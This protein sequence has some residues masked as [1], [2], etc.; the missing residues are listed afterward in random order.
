[1]GYH[2]R[3]DNTL[4]P[5]DAADGLL[6]VEQAQQQ[7]ALLAKPVE[8]TEQLALRDALDRVLGQA[9]ISPINVPPHRNSA[10]DGYAIRGDDL[11]DDGERSLRVI[12]TAWAGT[13]FVGPVDA[14]QCVRIMTGAKLPDDTDTVIMQEMVTVDGSTVQIATGHR[15]GENVRHPGEDVT[16]GKP[17]L[18]AGTH[19]GPAEL[20]LLASLGVAEVRVRRRLR[21]AFFSSGDELRAPG[22]PLGDG[23]IYDSNRYSLYGMLHR[24]N[25]E[26]LDMGVIRDRRSDVI[27]AFNSAAAIAD[28]VITSGGVS[29]GDADYVQETL[30]DLGHVH[31]WKIAMKPGKPLA[32][33]RIGNACF[34]GLPGNPVAVM[35]TFYQLVQPALRQMMGMD[36][37]QPLT[38]QVPTMTRLKKSPGR[39]DFQ[40][41]IL[42]H[43]ESG[44]LVVRSTGAQGSHVLSSMAQ[45]NCFI[46]LPAESGS[47]EA[48]TPVTVQPFAGLI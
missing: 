35:A 2:S 13:P 8:G 24:L 38:L 42:G 6:S 32:F 26:L 15:R 10:M 44:R 12:G 30:R 4:T 31:F 40:R 27:E 36:Q 20:G 45:A 37:V 19:I 1:M 5:C 14:G 21:V 33:G 17:V 34:F 9:A 23:Q 48:D 39:T 47:I 43:D 3:M 29:V 18:T 41:G 11:P 25:V 22:E 16:A 46:V 28:V 7:I